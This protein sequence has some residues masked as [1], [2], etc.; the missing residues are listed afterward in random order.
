ME[1]VNHFFS[2]RRWASLLFSSLS[3][4]LSIVSLNWFLIG[5]QF[6]ARF[7]GAST[8]FGTNVSSPQRRWTEWLGSPFCTCRFLVID[9]ACWLRC[10]WDGLGPLE[11]WSF[12]VQW[13]SAFQ[14]WVSGFS[15]GLCGNE[16][17]FVSLL[18]YLIHTCKSLQATCPNVLK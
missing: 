15:I 16:D 6:W 12:H 13:V 5:L 8:I 3:K 10:D 11:R 14:V 18:K 4:I 9:G 2:S 1:I 17:K 7:F